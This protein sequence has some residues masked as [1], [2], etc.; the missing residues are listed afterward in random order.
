ML[1]LSEVL[2]QDDCILNNKVGG[3]DEASTTLRENQHC[4]S[5]T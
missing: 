1:K 2:F 3:G 5:E 4:P